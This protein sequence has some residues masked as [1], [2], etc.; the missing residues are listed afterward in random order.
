MYVPHISNT[1]RA[2]PK[3]FL[4]LIVPSAGPPAMFKILAD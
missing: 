4:A 2:G 1:S 3:N